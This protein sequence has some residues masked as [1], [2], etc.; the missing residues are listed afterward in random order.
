MK[1]NTL[2]V[3][4]A[5][6]ACVFGLAFVLIPSQ[7]YPLY[8]VEP[9]AQLNFMGQLF[10]VT[11]LTIA[12]VTYL[13]R[14]VVDPNSR[15]SLVSALFVGNGIGFVVSLIGQLS[16]VVSAFGWSTVAIYF[17]LALG[18]ASFQFRKQPGS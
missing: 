18:F 8:A 10:G 5:L 17:L 7:V 2:L 11:L 12:L 15:K 16:V 13:M 1:L 3:I 6:L 9:N 4:N 14:N